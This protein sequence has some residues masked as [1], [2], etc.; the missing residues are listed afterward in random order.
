MAKPPTVAIVG[1]GFAGTEAAWQLNRRGFQVHLYEMRPHTKS[2]AHQTGDLAELVCSNS[3][4]STA[5]ANAHGLLKAEMALQSSLIVEQ[6]YLSRIPAGTALAVDRAVFSKRV[7][8]KI[9]SAENITIKR[10][11]VTDIT[12]LL[13]NYEKVIIASGPLTSPA[14]AQSISSYTEETYLYFYD[15]IA[16]VIAADSIDTSIVF[17]A[18]RY[19]R[20]EADYL[21]VPMSESEYFQFIKEILAAE[22]VAFHDFET[23][24]VFEGCMPIEA[25]AERGPQTLAF[26]PMKPV[27]LND[28][29]TGKP[30]YA[31]VQ[32][33]QENQE[34]TLYGMV[35][36]QTKMTWGEQRRIFRSLPGLGE[37][38]FV[39]MGS[40]HRNTF[41]NTP[42]LLNQ[43]LAHKTE[44]R[45]HFA[46]QITGVEGYMEST[47]MGLYVAKR[48]AY[49]LTGREIPPPSP[50]T[51]TG[52][53]LR[54][55]TSTSVSSF[56]PMNAAFGLVLP[57]NATKGPSLADTTKKQRKGFYAARAL[58]EMKSLEA[59]E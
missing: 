33:R 47:A 15:A 40:L 37:A 7:T 23:L 8:E 44:T 58:E 46:G 43:S 12:P 36:F 45:L 52:A 16:P 21:N 53:L 32:L 13:E 1:A 57:L 26:G 29:R 10:E 3:F 20:G 30:P 31:V 39:R 22:K 50:A 54:Y 19:D 56:Q 28:P 51:M 59:L 41:I 27:G 38:D 5:E 49:E 14:L 9:E 11:E 17:R 18:T 34:A 55:V 2:E 6:A 4:K 35:G 42:Q 25:M 24:R 48:V